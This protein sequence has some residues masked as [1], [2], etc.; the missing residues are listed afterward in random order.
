M[1]E[2][3]REIVG[4][5]NYEKRMMEMIKIG[6]GAAAKKALRLVR[7]RLGSMRRAKSKRDE[8]ENALQAMKHAAEQRTEEPKKEEAKKA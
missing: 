1:R 7:K 6:T 3:V 2:I 8:L 5:S 4:F